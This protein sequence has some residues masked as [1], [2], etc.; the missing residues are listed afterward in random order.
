MSDDTW[1][2]FI[3]AFFGLMT[4]LATVTG[5]ILSRATHRIVNSKL[6]EWKSTFM[7]SE[8]AKGKLE[9]LDELAD[10]KS[11]QIA[12]EAKGRSELL[13]EQHRSEEPIE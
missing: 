13:K 5:A 12:S 10:I 9:A 6:D 7:A 8:R 4:T 11:I 1:Q 2:I 3:T